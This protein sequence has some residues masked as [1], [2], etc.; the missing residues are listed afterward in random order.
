MARDKKE[1]SR[2]NADERKRGTDKE[3][4]AGGGKNEARE[5]E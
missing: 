4:E 1:R 5:R 2:M 3:N